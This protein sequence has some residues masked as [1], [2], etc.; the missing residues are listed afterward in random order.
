MAEPILDDELRAK[1][2]EFKREFLP[3]MPPEIVKA[4]G[5]SIVEMVGRGLAARAI[6]VGEKAPDF[7]LPDARGGSITLSERLG[8]GPAVIT[9][10][11]GGW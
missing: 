1:I 7:T 11:R 6:G 5:G 8:H 3:K 10:Y 2:D 9:F 4:I